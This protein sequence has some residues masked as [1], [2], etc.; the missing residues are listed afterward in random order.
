MTD[1]ENTPDPAG[2]TPERTLGYWL[3]A[4]NHLV[5]AQF[6]EAFADADIHS[7]EEAHQ[8]RTEVA[9]ALRERMA[10]A[11]S[12]EDHATTIASLEAIARELGW[13]ESADSRPER[14]FGPARGLGRGFGPARG[15]RPGFG[16][17]HGFGPDVEH[18][19][20]PARGFRHGFGRA[21]A[22]GFGRGLGR[23]I[24]PGFARG[25]DRDFGRRHSRDDHGHDATRETER[26]FERGFEAG[27]RAG[28]RD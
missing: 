5:H 16:P 9:D 12:P 10:A 11:I 19:F 25:F 27:F 13:D 3:R 14:G 6:A 23:G 24:H 20:G 26:S 15:F 4:V 28:S 22:P 17:A 7:R 1:T 21:F 8:V 2:E 18:G